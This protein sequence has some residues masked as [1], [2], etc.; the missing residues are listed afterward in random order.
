MKKYYIFSINRDFYEVYKKNEDVLYKTLLNLYNLDI[1]EA[2]YGISVF[3]QLCNPINKELVTSHFHTK[4]NAFKIDYNTFLKINPSCMI[5]NTENEIPLDF[6]N[7]NYY[8]APLFMIDFKNKN[9]FWL[10]VDKMI[11]V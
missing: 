9:Y 11:K 8:E 3:N 6:L 1:K 2:H 4:E 10:T 7:L 5:M